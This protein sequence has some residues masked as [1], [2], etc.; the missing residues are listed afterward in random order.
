[1]FIHD[2]QNAEISQERKESS[3][4]AERQSIKLN[5]VTIDI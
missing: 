2:K 3:D 4:S 1:M 5:A